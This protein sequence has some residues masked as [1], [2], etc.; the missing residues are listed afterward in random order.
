M[1]PP[2]EIGARSVTARAGGVGPDVKASRLSRAETKAIKALQ[3]AMAKK[4]YAAAGDALTKAKKVAKFDEAKHLV[5]ALQLQLGLATQNLAVQSDAVQ[6]L[7]TSGLTPK[8]SLPA[9]RQM[10]AALSENMKGPTG[11]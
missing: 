8:E 5:A 11:N 4:D 9:L 7:L 6:A 1:L 10:E 2:G 3:A